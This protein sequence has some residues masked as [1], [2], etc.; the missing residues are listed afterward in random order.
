MD[1]QEID[2][3]IDD[4]GEVKLEI[5]GVKGQKCLD[6]TQDLEAILGGEIISRE[7]TPEAGEVIQKIKNQEFNWS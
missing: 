6:L 3:F 5:R 7:M 2:V 1:L 4:N